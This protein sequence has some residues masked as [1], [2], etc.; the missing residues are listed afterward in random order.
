MVHRL[1]GGDLI[2]VLGDLGGSVTDR[3]AAGL[4]HVHETRRSSR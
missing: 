4:V 1:G 3:F 2:K